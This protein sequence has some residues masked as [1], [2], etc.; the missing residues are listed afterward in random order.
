MYIEKVTINNFR[1]YHGANSIVLT[2]AP[3]KSITVVSGDNGHG[4]T[5][6]LTSL[7]WCL[8]GRQMQEVDKFYKD[9]ILAASG[10][11]NYL[12]CSMNRLGLSKGEHEFYV[13]IHFKDVELPGVECSSMQITRTCNV[14]RR[15]DVLEIKMDGDNTELL[16]DFGQEAFIQDFIL[17]KEVA[18]FF[19][20]DAERI[21]AIAEIRSVEDKRLLA[22]AYSEVLGIKK[23][24][25][26]RNNLSDLRIRFRKDSAS[27]TEK[28]QF[29]ELGREINRLI[30]SA[31]HREL[32]KEKLLDKKKELR[33]KSDEFQEKLLRVGNPLT[34]SEIRSLESDKLTLQERG[35][36]LR[37]ELKDLFELAPFAIAGKLLTTIGNQLDAEERQKGGVVDKELLSSKIR[38]VVRSLKHDTDDVPPEVN[39]RIKDYYVAKVD[40]LLNRHFIKDEQDCPKKNVKILHDFTGEEKNGFDAVL[41]N[42]RSTYRHR[43]QT[44]YK[45]LKINEVQYSEISKKLADAESRETDALVM[46][47]RTEK[48]KADQRIRI[49]DEEILEVSESIGSLES[50]IVSKKK[51]Y[52]ELAKKIRVN[53]HYE[54]KDQAAAR[55]IGELDT[56]TRRM[57]LEKKGSLE[58]RILSSLNTLMHKKGFIREVAVEVGSDILDIHLMDGR[59]QEI[60]KDGLSRGEQQLYAT[61]IL[62]ALIE[63]SGM[64]FPILIDS[65]L[66]KFDDKH[67]RGVITGLYPHI[68]KQV[69]IFPLLNKELSEEDYGLLVEHVS[70]AVIINSLGEDRSEFLE[71]APRELFSEH[72]Q[73]SAVL[74][75]VAVNQNIRS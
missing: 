23:Y 24:E 14:L 32:R 41:S 60:D 48:E 69:V 70:S 17:P 58:R 47:Y 15:D 4:K 55:L 10:Y 22:Q 61:A 43:L 50:A 67:T 26:L 56:F 13:S 53:E 5:S 38:R 18:R 49:I 68:S 64:D 6:F 1:I 9:R 30:E 28:A 37:S 16:D 2:P 52:E 34:L 33:T 66:Q 65:P 44:L 7:V 45:S 31:K 57:R 72:D 74:I 25:D 27:T 20:L 3:N 11:R 36:A 62:K 73:S 54:G 59:G 19:F 12:A 40:E 8:Y 71:V 63:E 51:L 35:K 39:S 21:V 29:E 42:L 46:T 75:D